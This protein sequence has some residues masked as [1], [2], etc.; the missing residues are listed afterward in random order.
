MAVKLAKQLKD[1]NLQSLAFQGDCTAFSNHCTL[2]W[3]H[4]ELSHKPNVH[5]QQLHLNKY[6]HMQLLQAE[7]RFPC[8]LLCRSK[9]RLQDDQFQHD[10]RLS[11]CML[12]RNACTATVTA[13]LD[14]SQCGGLNVAQVACRTSQSDRLGSGHDIIALFV[15]L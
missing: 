12:Y 3:C 6:G 15:S 13:G 5:Q 11:V 1:W 10:S 8:C 9:V 14:N 7:I 2:A 4:K